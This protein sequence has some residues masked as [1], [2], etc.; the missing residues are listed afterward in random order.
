MQSCVMHAYK[1]T[2]LPVSAAGKVQ[3]RCKQDT[4][5]VRRAQIKKVT[6]HNSQLQ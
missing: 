3:G 4:D 2:L 5:P 6:L 1:F